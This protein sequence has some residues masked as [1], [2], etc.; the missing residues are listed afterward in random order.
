MAR[1][2]PETPAIAP[3]IIIPMMDT[4]AFISTF[5]LTI[6]GTKILLSIN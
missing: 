1:N 5:E 3:P 6:I 4:K 2:I